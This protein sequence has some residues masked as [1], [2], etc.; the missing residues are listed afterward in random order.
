MTFGRLQRRQDVEG[1]WATALP[2][3]D[4][5]PVVWCWGGWKM[6]CVYAVQSTSAARFPLCQSVASAEPPGPVQPSIRRPPR[7]SGPDVS[8]LVAQ[9]AKKW[10]P[11]VTL[12]KGYS[13]CVDGQRR[14][15]EYNPDHVICLSQKEPQ[16]HINIQGTVQW[17]KQAGHMTAGLNSERSY[18]SNLWIYEVTFMP[19]HAAMHASS[20]PVLH[21]NNH[22]SCFKKER[23]QMLFWCPRVWKWESILA[24][25]SQHKGEPPL[26]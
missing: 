6:K 3:W 7:L 14:S 26:L 4:V 1:M 17:E 8:S 11:P 16:K 22:Y 24:L 13:C 25:A 21:W 9:L 20:G 23:N 12:L 2:W 18:W 5:L 19:Y 10:R 15:M